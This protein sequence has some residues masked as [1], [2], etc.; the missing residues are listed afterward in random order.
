M[1]IDHAKVALKL[2]SKIWNSN[3][4]AYRYL[5]QSF[6]LFCLSLSIFKILL[7][8][9]HVHIS[10]MKGMCFDFYGLFYAYYLRMFITKIILFSCKFW[11]LSICNL[12]ASYKFCQTKIVEDL[13]KK[14]STSAYFKN[15]IVP[16]TD[17]FA[18]IWIPS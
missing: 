4:V 10:I 2:Q 8:K 13:K 11:E 3:H 5:Q 12:Q 15:K 7:C 18:L 9:Q 6:F 14:I 1:F 16:I 17:W